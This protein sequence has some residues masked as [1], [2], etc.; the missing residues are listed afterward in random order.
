[1]LHIFTHSFAKN[2]T[3]ILIINSKIVYNHAEAKQMCTVLKLFTSNKQLTTLEK[4]AYQ[5]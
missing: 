2:D 4:G 3:V 5:I 1:M